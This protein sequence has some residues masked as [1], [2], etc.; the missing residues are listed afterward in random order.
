MLDE[1]LENNAKLREIVDQS[2]EQKT[3]SKKKLS[4]AGCRFSRSWRHAS[5]VLDEAVFP[6][7]LFSCSCYAFS[8]P[9]TILPSR[10]HTC[11]SIA[12][13]TCSSYCGGTI[14]YSSTRVC[15][16]RAQTYNSFLLT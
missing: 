4:R 14:W 5:N 9:E 13:T 8:S 2:K 7:A 1:K 11:T 6:H 10:L 3:Q 12:A 15:R 16:R